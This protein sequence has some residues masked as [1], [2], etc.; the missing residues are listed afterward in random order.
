M[1]GWTSNA[2]TRTKPVWCA[3]SSND[4]SLMLEA[5]V[6][7]CLHIDR[8]DWPCFYVFSFLFEPKTIPN[9]S[10]SPGLWTEGAKARQDFGKSWVICGQGLHLGP[11]DYQVLFGTSMIFLHLFQRLKGESWGI[12]AMDKDYQYRMRIKT[13]RM[14]I[15]V[16]MCF[17]HWGLM[18]SSQGLRLWRWDRDDYARTRP[19]IPGTAPEF[20]LQVLH[21]P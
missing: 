11:S 21:Q 8:Q 18:C 13:S 9:P 19:L 5:A 14:S 3:W 4:K 15:Q 16:S 6:W 20:W 2:S 7:M 17:C 1:K 12:Y 10:T